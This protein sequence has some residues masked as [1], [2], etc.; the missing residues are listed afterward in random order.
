MNSYGQHIGRHIYGST[1]DQVFWLV[2][3]LYR[4][5][6]W[7]NVDLSLVTYHAHIIVLIEH[8]FIIYLSQQIK[9]TTFYHCV[10]LDY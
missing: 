3:W 2:V 7:T 4:G 8:L 6:T 9:N 10:N 1:L 5:T